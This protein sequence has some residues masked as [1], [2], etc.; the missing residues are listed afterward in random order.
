MQTAPLDTNHER[1]LQA[2]E[3]L[4]PAAV[5]DLI[6]RDPHQWSKPGCVTCRSVAQL[7]GRPFVCDRSR[8]RHHAGRGA[9]RWTAGLV[10]AV[11]G[12][13]PPGAIIVLSATTLRPPPMRA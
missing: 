13:G 5:F 8:A 7:I 11:K 2:L 10:G 4:L 3:A 12:V 9:V 1:R 6:Q